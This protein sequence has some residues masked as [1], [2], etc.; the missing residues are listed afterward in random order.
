[1][2][3]IIRIHYVSKHNPAG[4][5]FTFT[6]KNWRNGYKD[7]RKLALE[8]IKNEDILFYMPGL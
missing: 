3:K 7:K 8:K 4:E 1:M 5:I 6:E 2:F